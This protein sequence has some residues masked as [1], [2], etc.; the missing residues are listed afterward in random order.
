MKLEPAVIMPCLGLGI[1]TFVMLST[2]S[3]LN[4]SFN[5]SLSRFGGD[6]AVGAMTLFLPA[7]SWCCCRFR[8]FVRADSL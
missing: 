8:E 5:S 2:E 4:I 3:I 1:S 6:V 7:A